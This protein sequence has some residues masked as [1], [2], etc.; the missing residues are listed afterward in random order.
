[1]VEPGMLDRAVLRVCG[2]DARTF[3]QNLL[4]QDLDR[5]DRDGL[6]YSAL[7]TPQGKV[8]AD[9]LVWAQDD[10][11]LL[12]VDP[13]RSGDLMRRL[14]LYKLRAQVVI[15][16]VSATW[17]ARVSAGPDQGARP[18]PRLAALG[19]RAIAPRKQANDSA[20]QAATLLALGAPDLARD[21][22]PE[23]VFALEALLEELDG[24]AFHKGCFIGQEN[25]SRM[26]RRATTRRKFCPIVFEGEAPA[27]ATP[28]LAGDAEIGA[29][30]SAT[31]GRAL[32]LLRLDR[33]L[34]SQGGLSL[35]GRPARLDPPSW[36]LLPAA[37]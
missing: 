10:N 30:R 19:W 37:G 18:D 5:L 25:V 35:A 27:F 8:I 21:A 31:P 24:V 7:L 4:T 17:T 13:L 11:L 36:L 23:E 29:T 2:A 1:M 16:D 12:D 3:L 6:L 32:A 20:N 9:M 22:A 15:E 33:A 26:K 28:V 14:Q 34:S